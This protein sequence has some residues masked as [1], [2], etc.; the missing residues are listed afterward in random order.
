M[1]TQ[2]L[3]DSRHKNLFSTCFGV[4]L[5]SKKNKSISHFLR[6]GSNKLVWSIFLNAIICFQVLEDLLNSEGLPAIKCY[7]T[8]LKVQTSI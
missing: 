5:E 2:L 4:G 1:P 3:S 6:F 7:K 8:K